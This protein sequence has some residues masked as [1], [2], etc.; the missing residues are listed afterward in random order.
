[1]GAATV[2]VLQPDVF[3][4]WRIPG[5][6]P[7]AL[8]LGAGFGCSAAEVALFSKAPD[9]STCGV[10]CKPAAGQLA[11]PVAL[12]YLVTTGERFI[13]AFWRLV[14]SPYQPGGFSRKDDRAICWKCGTGTDGTADEC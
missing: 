10:G 7:T 1:L 13:T 9:V 4:L 12:A 3:P 11:L 5:N 2:F 6:S 8:S 14:T